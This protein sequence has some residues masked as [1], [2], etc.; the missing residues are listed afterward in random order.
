MKLSNL[1]KTWILDLDGTLIKHNGHKS[2]EKVLPSVKKFLA[3]I[4]KND[5]ILILTGR[6][7]KYAKVTKAFLSK[8]NIRY[9]KIVFNM[10]VGERIL[11]N[12]IKPRENLHTAICFNVPR[13]EGMTNIYNKIFQSCKIQKSL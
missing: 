6:K 12:D 11:I 7:S 4:P 2:E 10:P 1:Q 13:N 8:N 9:N 5:F 3:K